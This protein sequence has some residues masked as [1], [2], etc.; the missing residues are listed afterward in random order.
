MLK[1]KPKYLIILVIVLFVFLGSNDTM[2]KL[3]GEMV[4]SIVFLPAFS[5]FF[6]GLVIPNSIVAGQG[7]FL[8]MVV[9]SC[10]FPAMLLRWCLPERI[11]V[12]TKYWP[13]ICFMMGCSIFYNGEYSWYISFY[14]C[15]VPALMGLACGKIIK[16][17][18]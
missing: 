10:F 4:V 1:L 12:I 6:F 16:N 8:I 2:L 18:Q 9:V 14:L 5:V 11:K 17:W 7:P 15:V 13:L 3:L